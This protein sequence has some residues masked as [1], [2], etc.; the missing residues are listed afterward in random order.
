MLLTVVNPMGEGDATE[1]I[2]AIIKNDSIPKELKK[3][4]YDL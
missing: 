3:E 1:K 4:F 2:M